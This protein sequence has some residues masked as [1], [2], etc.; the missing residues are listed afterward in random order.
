MALGGLDKMDNLWDIRQ[1]FSPV[2][3]QERGV[4]DCKLAINATVV[5]VKRE[6]CMIVS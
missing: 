2:D 5:G 6:V 3:K 4:Y 1:P